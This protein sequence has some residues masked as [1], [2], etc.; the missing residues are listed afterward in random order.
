[1]KSRSELDAML[2]DLEVRMPKLLAACEKDDMQ[3]CFTQEADAI[4]A[5]AREE[6]RP[7]VWGRL[8][9]IQGCAGL[10]PTDENCADKA[11]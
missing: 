3:D 2:D 5:H 7:H 1:M 9:H 11:L 8:N 4:D 10:I 6:D